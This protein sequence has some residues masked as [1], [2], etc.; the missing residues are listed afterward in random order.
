MK[1][2]IYGKEW[3]EAARALHRGEG[4]GCKP[5]SHQ[6]CP[7]WIS[8][9]KYRGTSTIKTKACVSAVQLRVLRR[10]AAWHKTASNMEVAR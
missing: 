7:H 5:C 2:D 10:A 6:Y 9:Q 3:N 4:L 1:F 8:P